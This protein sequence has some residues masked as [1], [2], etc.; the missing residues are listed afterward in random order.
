MYWLAINREWTSITEL[1]ADILPPV[2]KA[3]LWEALE[4]LNGRSLVEKQADSY[5]QQSVVMEY[6]TDCLIDRITNELLT[7]T[8]NLLITH[9][10]IK[11][12]VKDDIRETQIRLILQPIANRLQT[13]LGSKLALNQHI[14]SILQLLRRSATHLSGY[15]GGNLINL[16][17]QLQLDLTDYDFSHLKISHAYLQ[18]TPL[19]RVNFSHCHLEKSV[20]AQT[21]GGVVSA[22]FSP[23][24]KRLATGENTSDVHLWCVTSG[25]LLL[26]LQGHTNLVW[27][28][29]WSPDGQT[30]ATSSSD[31]TI[32]LWDTRTGRC[33][34][35]LLGHSNWVWF[36]AWSADGQTLASGSSDETIK[37]WDVNTGECQKTLKSQPPYQ[38]MNIT[39][40]TGLTDAQK[41]TLKRLGATEIIT[42][43]S[44][45]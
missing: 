43:R 12:I 41:A 5:T 26:T 6:V 22:A 8:L 15:G 39:Q 9:A 10:L 31:Q 25:Q 19:H 34:K 44:A 37:V 18:T 35:T 29:A 14:Q 4:T 23:D 28:V 38:G 3:E 36:V 45:I 11:T 7:K 21:L 27:S 32:K 24:G 16:C 1:A 20:F 30:L 13:R 2:S 40:I 17:V 42:V 33:L